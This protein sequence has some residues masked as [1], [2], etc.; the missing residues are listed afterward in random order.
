[1]YFKVRIRMKLKI[2]KITNS[3]TSSTLN[4]TNIKI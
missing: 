3:K 2:R 1:M 4:D